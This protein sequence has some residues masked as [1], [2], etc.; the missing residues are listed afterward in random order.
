MTNQ[1]I[2][3]RLL[4]AAGLSIAALAPLASADEVK[5]PASAQGW[6]T[7]FDGKLTGAFRG[8]HSEG[9]PDGWK[10]VNGELT[11]REMSMTW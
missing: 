2:L 11:K 8:W 5:P 9:M 7:L 3:G 4:L 10:V 6:Q 1:K